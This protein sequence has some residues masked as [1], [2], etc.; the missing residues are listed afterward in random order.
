MLNVYLFASVLFFPNRRGF[1]LTGDENFFL[2]FR[3]G[4]DDVF[5]CGFEKFFY[6]NDGKSKVEK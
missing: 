2:L 3:R 1:S 5:V 6:G 4:M